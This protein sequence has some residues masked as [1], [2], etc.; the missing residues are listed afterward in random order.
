M[1]DYLA[2]FAISGS[3]MAVEKLRL[4][5]TAVNLANVN[6]SK[7]ADGALFRPLRVVSGVRADPRFEAAMRA[8]GVQLGGSQVQEIRPTDTAPRLVHEPG[9]P[10]A[11]ARGFVSYPG[12][13]PVAE[14]TNLITAVRSYEAN[15]VALNA[16]K[17][18]AQRALDIGGGR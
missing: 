10:D 3:G 17:V 4:D 16:A 5:V 15:V 18:M 14:M 11:D 12:V 8:W 2:A 1:M 6:S 13:N 7:G 9:H